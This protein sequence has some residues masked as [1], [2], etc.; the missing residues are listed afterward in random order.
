MKAPF[1][2]IGSERPV[3]GSLHFLHRSHKTEALAWQSFDQTLLFAGIAN[4]TP[5]NVQPRRQCR[6]GHDAAVPYGIDEIVLAHDPFPVADQVI[7]QVEYLWR[8]R[9][10]LRPAMELAQAGVECV[11]LEQIPQAANSLGGR[12]LSSVCNILDDRVR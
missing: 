5:G 1:A 3:P 9:D 8:N 2:K 6:T 12:R 4:R 10:D 7:E 11:I